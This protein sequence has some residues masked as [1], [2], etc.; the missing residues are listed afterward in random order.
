MKPGIIGGKRQLIEKA[1]TKMFAVVAAASVVVAFSIVAINFMWDQA[2]YNDR[3][4][5]EKEAARDT[6][7]SNI[8]SATSLREDLI[9]LNEQDD[10]IK[11]QDG[12]S[13]TA[14]VL[15]AL[16]RK[17][18]FPALRTSID[19][20][21]KISGVKLLGF[22]GSDNESDA[23]QT[24]IDPVPEPIEFSMSVEGDYDAI[25]QFYQDI[26]NTIRPLQITKLAMSGKD[27]NM[28]LALNVITYY[29]PSVNVE[30]QTKVVE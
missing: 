21:T 4:H 27:S 17:Y 26:E 23:I 29:Q 8:A 19:K 6:L 13:N 30:I 14:V 20:L 3:V 12:K 18:D 10:I 24:M 11:G 16:P 22:N 1:N 9:E 15:D 2:S 25:N 5:T 28:T 7:E